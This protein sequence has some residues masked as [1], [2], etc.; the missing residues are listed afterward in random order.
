MQQE[1]FI[2]FHLVSIRDM[3][4]QRTRDT[5]YNDRVFQ[6]LTFLGI[7]SDGTCDTGAQK[8]EQSFHIAALLF[9][10]FVKDKLDKFS[11]L[12]LVVWI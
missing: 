5:T 1:F 4:D 2:S 10:K 12:R 6:H 9:G 11:D 8:E 3:F 7:R